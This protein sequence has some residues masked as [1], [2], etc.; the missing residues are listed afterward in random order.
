MKMEFKKFKNYDEKELVNEAKQEI[1]RL[2]KVLEAT[3]ALGIMGANGTMSQKE[4]FTC[5]VTDCVYIAGY[6]AGADGKIS[7]R[8]LE[9]ASE[10]FGD[11]INMHDFKSYYKTDEMIRQAY[12]CAVDDIE[13]NG[14]FPDFIKIM[15]QAELAN[16][17]G[18][19]DLSETMDHLIFDIMF[20]GI[21][22]AGADG[23]RKKSEKKALDKLF[24]NSEQFFSSKF[25]YSFNKEARNY[26]DDL[27]QSIPNSL[28]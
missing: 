19:E 16:D 23:K 18:Y 5:F 17:R 27:Y 26:L 14:W 20:I 2:K 13:N 8:E 7:D 22:I 6:I 4:I 12:N 21:I 9:I 1:E 25:A 10:I 3:Y 11:T 28:F 15:F 24:T